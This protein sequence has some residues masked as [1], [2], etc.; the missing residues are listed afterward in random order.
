[1][2]PEGMTGTQSSPDD[3]LRHRALKTAYL[4]ELHTPKGEEEG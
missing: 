3:Q 1:M 4:A 2:K